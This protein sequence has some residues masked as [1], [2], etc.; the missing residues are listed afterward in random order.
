MHGGLSNAQYGLLISLCGPERLSARELAD[1]AELN[2]ATVTQMLEALQEAGLVTRQRSEQDRRVVLNSL[3]PHGRQLVE[4]YRA[5]VEPRW[6]AAMSEFSDEQLADAAAVL[7]RL[8]TV[9]E[10]WDAPEG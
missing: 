1:A 10:D 2:A 6:R 8:A 4:S 9:L 3:T 7:E 5:R